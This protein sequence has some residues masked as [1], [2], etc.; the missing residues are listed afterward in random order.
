M[1]L[2]ADSHSNLISYHFSY[3]EERSY[4]TYSVSISSLISTYFNLV[5]FE[6]SR[7]YIKGGSPRSVNVVERR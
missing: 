1:F 2:Y 6:H 3:F 4:F 5:S 7:G